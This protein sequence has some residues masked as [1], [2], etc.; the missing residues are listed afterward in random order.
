MAKRAEEI[1]DVSKLNN[2][3]LSGAFKNIEAYENNYT[4][5]MID[6]MSKELEK[7]RIRNELILNAAGEGIYG[8]DNKGNTT[9][10]NPAAAE[11]IGWDPDELI[12]K[13]QHKI[14]HHSRADG[15]HYPNTECPIYAAFKDGKVH[16]VKDEVF[17]RKD[18]SSFPV[19]YV[20]TPIFEKEKL[21]GAVVVF[22]DVTKEREAEYALRE[23]ICRS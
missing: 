6:E 14:L 13:S 1:I 3:I 16:V 9:F 20:S 2:K 15:S 8:L 10:V 5:V 21:V 19:E 12:G 4:H 18:G 7:L 22:R 11:M 17:W 23:R